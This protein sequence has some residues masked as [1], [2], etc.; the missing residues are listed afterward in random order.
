M[1][2]S[3]KE[4]AGI[5][6]LNVFLVNQ[7]NGAFRTISYHKFYNNRFNTF[8]LKCSVNVHTNKY[9]VLTTHPRTDD[10]IYGLIKLAAKLNSDCILIHKV[11]VCDIHTI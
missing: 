3:F 11:L 7:W 6:S 10:T 9:Y 5:S 4:I 1:K 8:L 2:T